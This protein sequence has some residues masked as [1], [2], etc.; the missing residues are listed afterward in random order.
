MAQRPGAKASGSQSVLCNHHSFNSRR[1]DNWILAYRSDQGA[2]LERGDQR[3]RGRAGDG[4][5]HVDHDEQKDHGKICGRRPV[6][7]IRVDSNAGY[8][9]RFPRNDCDL[10]YGLMN[11][12]DWTK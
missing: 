3:R 10:L 1:H 5:D 11:W 7:S 2:I 9:S 6:A 12:S 4:H 8:G